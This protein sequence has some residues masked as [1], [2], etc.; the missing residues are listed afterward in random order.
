[1]KNLLKKKYQFFLEGKSKINEDFSKKLP[2]FWKK[3]ENVI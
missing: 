3:N 2:A 1:M